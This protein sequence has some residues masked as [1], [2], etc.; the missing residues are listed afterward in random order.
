MTMLLLNAGSHANVMYL[1][2]CF[3]STDE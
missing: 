3:N 2:A 1:T